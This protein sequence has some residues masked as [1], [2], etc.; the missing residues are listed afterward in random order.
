MITCF[1]S[2]TWVR[3]SCVLTKVVYRLISSRRR[4]FTHSIKHSITHSISHAVNQ[5]KERQQLHRKIPH[6]CK[7]IRTRKDQGLACESRH[8]QSWLARQ[9]FSHGNCIVNDV[10]PVFR[11]GLFSY[12][13]SNTCLLV[14]LHR[15]NFWGVVNL[16]PI[17]LVMLLLVSGIF[18][19]AISILHIIVMVNL[20]SL[21]MVAV[22]MRSYEYFSI[23]CIAV[24]R[25]VL[26]RD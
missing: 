18:V 14:S 7:H 26:V 3:Q 5:P 1:A 23:S 9:R 11:T 13:R 15:S 21:A 2:L 22:R 6:I 19:L 17:P 4:R 24:S 12:R 8:R 20:I 25:S 16:R 10:T